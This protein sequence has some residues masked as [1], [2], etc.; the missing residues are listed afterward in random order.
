MCGGV[1]SLSRD[2][3]TLQR[4]QLKD[5]ESAGMDR[6]VKYATLPVCRR[7]LQPA[8]RLALRAPS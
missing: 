1:P 3:K 2:S 4:L 6:C 5:Y 7:L 8:R